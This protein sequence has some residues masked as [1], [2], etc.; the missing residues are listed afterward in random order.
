MKLVFWKNHFRGH[1][2]PLL[3]TA[4]KFDQKFNFRFFS[5]LQLVP[6]KFLQSF[7]HRKVDVFVKF[8]LK[9]FEKLGEFR[10]SIFSRFYV[11]RDCFDTFER[12]TEFGQ[13]FGGT[14]GGRTGLSGRR[15]R[16]FRFFEHFGHF[17]LV[18]IHLERSTLD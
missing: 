5:K 6:Q 16:Y 18:D 7:G 11:F 9:L 17:W 2:F 12:F 13:R 8:R 1:I 14:V 3:K 10:I 4:Y 15:T